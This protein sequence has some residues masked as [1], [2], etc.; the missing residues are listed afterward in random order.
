MTLAQF[1]TYLSA[2][3]CDDDGEQRAAT[4]RRDPED[5]LA[6]RTR[7]RRQI[8]PWRGSLLNASDKPGVHIN[9]IAQ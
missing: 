5:G 9:N 1:S 3:G 6:I 7:R 4:D 2:Y 8:C